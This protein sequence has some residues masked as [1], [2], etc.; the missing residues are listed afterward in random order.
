M[1]D[2]KDI[3]LERLKINQDT[4]KLQGITLLNFIRWYGT[5]SGQTELIPE[6]KITQSSIIF[7]L[8]GNDNR[9][10]RSSEQLADF[11]RNNKD[12]QLENYSE[13]TMYDSNN[14]VKGFDI[15][16]RIDDTNFKV[17]VSESLLEYLDKNRFE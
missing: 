17:E 6:N 11:F 8:R 9:H 7:G 2:L 12:K 16:F 3:L 5:P 1:K 14:K 10:L 4:Y 13:K 15:K